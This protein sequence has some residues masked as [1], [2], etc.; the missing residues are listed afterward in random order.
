MFDNLVTLSGDSAA[1]GSDD[2]ME[3]SGADDEEEVTEENASQD[4]TAQEGSESTSTEDASADA[5]K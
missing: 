1:A 2:I 3:L 4:G 5:S